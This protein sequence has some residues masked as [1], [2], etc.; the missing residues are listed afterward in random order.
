M[1]DNPASESSRVRRRPQRARRRHPEAA[2]AG[3]RTTVVAVRGTSDRRREAAGSGEKHAKGNARGSPEAV[4]GPEPRIVASPITV[5]AP[6]PD[7]AVH[8]VE[9]E[10][11]RGESADGSVAR[12]AV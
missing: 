5:G 4:R 7:V 8:V 6:L 1:K 12:I 3:R 10:G 2:T 11:V 9:P